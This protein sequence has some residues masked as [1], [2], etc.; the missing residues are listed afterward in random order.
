MG[1]KVGGPSSY[2]TLLSAPLVHYAPQREAV[3]SFAACYCHILCFL[4]FYVL[5]WNA[6]VFLAFVRVDQL[7]RDTSHV[8]VRPIKNILVR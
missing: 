8:S 1:G 7:S 5:N 2:N 6:S 3:C 4:L